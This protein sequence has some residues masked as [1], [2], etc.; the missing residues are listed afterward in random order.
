M[1]AE[2]KIGII[3]ILAIILFFFAPKL[4]QSETI[5]SEY[6]PFIQEMSAI[7]E[8]PLEIALAVAIIESNI[9]MVVSDQNS[10]GSFDVGIYQ[11]NNY[12]LDYFEEE[13][14][15]ESRFFD[16][17]SANDNIEMGIILLRNLYI[18]TG[19]WD[20]AVRAFHSGLHGLKKN[21]DLSRTY[22]IKI[23]N[24]VTTMRLK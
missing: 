11:L 8:V 10:N 20:D 23:V 9:S 16:P 1:K 13:F 18:Q 17:Y 2:T 21:P 12:Y 14:W 15:Y 5:N 6:L 22:F 24:I 19:G 7:H 4:V 3:F